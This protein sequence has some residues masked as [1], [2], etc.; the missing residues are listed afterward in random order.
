MGPV[1]RTII[2]TVLLD[3]DGVLNPLASTPP[4]GFQSQVID[5]FEVAISVRHRRWLQELNQ[6][7]E[8]VWA[9]TWE[10]S[11]NQSICPLLGL[12]TLRV[13]N[14]GPDRQGETWKLSDVRIVQLAAA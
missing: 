13:V 3:V 7:F 4:P 14:F 8:L 12:P 6:S 11:V 5:G 2:G 10:D 9:T 1:K